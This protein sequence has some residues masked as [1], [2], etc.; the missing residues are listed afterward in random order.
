MTKNLKNEIVIYQA[1][2]LPERIEVRLDDDTV[3]L[4]QEQLS[5]LFQRDQ[6][7]ISRHIRNIFKEGELE[8]ISNMQKMHIA[9][10]DKPVAYYKLDVIISV[11]Y[12]IKSKQG[13]LLRIW[14]TNVLRDYLLKGYVLNQRMNR[15]EN[16][17]DELS[18]KVDII[19]LQLESNKLPNQGIFWNLFYEKISIW[20]FLMPVPLI[21]PWSMTSSFNWLRLAIG[22]KS[23]KLLIPYIYKVFKFCSPFKKSMFATLLILGNTKTSNDFKLVKSGISSCW[24][25]LIFKYLKFGQL[26]MT[27]T[28]S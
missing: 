23:I 10:S 6:S 13:T 3:W 15:V 17:V 25:T 1:D 22:V 26:T 19:S 18:K 16:H 24:L 27:S 20:I 28:R 4:S 8:E 7:V 2:D 9:N 12:R 5:S 11:G 14:A 21:L